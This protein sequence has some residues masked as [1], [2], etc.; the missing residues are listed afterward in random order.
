MPTTRRQLL[1][2]LAGAVTLAAQSRPGQQSGPN[3]SG[4][5]TPAVILRGEFPD[6]TVVRAGKDFY[7]THSHADVYIPSLLIW[8]STDLYHW[9]PVCRALQNFPENIAAPE[10]IHY[11]DRF[12]IY[13]PSHRSN[14]VITASSPEGPWTSPVDLKVGGIDPGHVAT[15]DGTRYLYFN[16]GRAVQLAEDGLSVT[17][18]AT[19]SYR[20]WQYPDTWNVECF[21]LESPKLSFHNGYYYLTS[22]QGGTTGPTTSHM[23]VQARSRSPLGPWENSPYNPLVHTWRAAEPWW[24]KGHGTLVDDGSG[25]WYIVYHAYENGHRELGRQTLIEPLTYTAGGWFRS[26]WADGSG[27]APQIIRNNALEPDDFSGP[28]LKLQWGF[29][30]VKSSS[31]YALEKGFV[32]L[33]GAAGSFHAMHVRPSDPHYEAS[34]ALE[35]SGSAEYGLMLFY[36]QGYNAG[37]GLGK[38][39]NRVFNIRLDRAAFQSVTMDDC[40]Y[41]KLQVL[42]HDLATFCSPD[43]Q[44]W[45]R[46]PGGMDISGYQANTFGGFASLK[47]AA[48]IRGEGDLKISQFQYRP[49]QE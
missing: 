40:R 8:H 31:E 21:C 7:L 4:S 14:W 41:F 47:I 19:V 34:V 5:P 37:A 3:G 27:F 48:Y 32:R 17:D 36:R 30:G 10:L 6:P 28:A 2:S 44:V 12:Y 38:R 49:L 46:L 24:S 39:G 33:K 1:G 18:K 43:G 42:H 35:C 22:A 13:F 16:G 25:N 9:K 45:K 20:G 23:A 15:P 29:A 26:R 11:R